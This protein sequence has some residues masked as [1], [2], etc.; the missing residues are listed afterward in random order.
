M[1]QINLLYPMLSFTSNNMKLLLYLFS[2]SGSL[3]T[4]CYLFSPRVG[5]KRKLIRYFVFRVHLETSDY[6]NEPHA[7][8]RACCLFI[9]VINAS[10]NKCVCDN[11]LYCLLPRWSN[12]Y[13]S[14]TK[15]A[16]LVNLCYCT[17]WLSHYL[18]EN[19]LCSYMFSFYFD[20]L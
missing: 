4:K 10:A 5:P 1:Q 16:R 2:P 18:N 12:A 13:F 15:V 19:P 3:E 9:N 20:Y 11:I 8:N 6:T 7:E 17:K 14:L